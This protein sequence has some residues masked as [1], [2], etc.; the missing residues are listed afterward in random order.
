MALDCLYHTFE[1]AT[2]PVGRRSMISFAKEGPDRKAA[3]CFRPRASV[4][5]SLIIFPEPTS[6]PLLTDMM[7]TSGG[8]MPC[9]REEALSFNACYTLTDWGCIAEAQEPAPLQLCSP[10]TSDCAE[11]GPRELHTEHR[12]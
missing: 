12:R 7:G 8:R 2:T 11:R 5:T 9:M 1:A 10:G 4:M 6:K 3:G